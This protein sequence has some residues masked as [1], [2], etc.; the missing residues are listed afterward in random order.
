MANEHT[1]I[2]QRLQDLQPDALGNA[3]IDR[4]EGCVHGSWIASTAA[5]R[6][7]ECELRE[8]ISPCSLSPAFAARL[9]NILSA[10]PFPGSQ[11]VISF[12]ERPA[13]RKTRR[14]AA[15]AA[16]VAFAGALCA[17]FIP[18]GAQNSNHMAANDTA[19]VAAMPSPIVPASSSNLVPAS[20]NSNLSTTNDEGVLWDQ[21]G[22]PHKMIKLTY[23]ERITLKD[24][25]GKSHAFLR[26]RVEYVLVPT[27]ID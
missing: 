2:E 12:P 23:T 24:N 22:Q 1:E 21:E 4:L 14:L 9:E 18:G 15:I 27:N 8:H 3:L 17:W 20:Y 11:K 25:N 5:E 13:T 26:P 6:A 10:T 7:F 19:P 16:A